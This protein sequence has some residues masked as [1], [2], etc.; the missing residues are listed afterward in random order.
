MRGD[1][2]GIGGMKKPLSQT[3]CQ[4][5]E[6]NGARPDNLPKWEVAKIA[7]YSTQLKIK[8]VNRVIEEK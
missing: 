5:G 1:K 2:W 4:I 6:R 8:N 3:L 7:N